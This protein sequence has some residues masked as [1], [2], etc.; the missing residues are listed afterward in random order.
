MAR[1]ARKKILFINPLV[2]AGIK[3]KT[4]P[5]GLAYVMTA[6]KNADIEFDF[7]DMY[8]HS[9]SLNHLRTHIQRN[10]YDIFSIG[11]LV[12]GLR[13]VRD[14]AS[15]IRECRPGAK[16][17]AGNTVASSIPE[18]ILRK[19]EVDIAV[20]GEGD[21]TIVELLR[22]LRDGRKFQ[23]IEGIAYLDHG[24]IRKNR[25]RAC[26]PDINTIGFPDWRL[27]NNLCY[28]E[29]IFS[30]VK[31]GDGRTV[32]YPLN[33]ARGCPFKCSYCYHVFKADPY[34]RYSED[35]ILDEIRRLY[36]EYNASVIQFSDELT[37]P[38]IS[39]IKR[40]VT[41][42]EALPFNIT[43]SAVT[44]PDLFRKK[45]VSLIRQMRDVGCLYLCMGLENA[46]QE[47]LDAM[48][49][50]VRVGRV[51]EHLTALQEGGVTP[52][53]SVIFGFPQ[54]TPKTIRET[55]SLCE[56]FN[57]VPGV[58]FLQPFPG[59]PIYDW[60]IQNRYIQDPFKYLLN[61]GDREVFHV[62]L[63]KMPTDEFIDIVV[64]GIYDLA[65]RLKRI[66]CSQFL[67]MLDEYHWQETFRDSFET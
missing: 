1:S 4:R 35:A 55:Y 48:N 9:L 42:L 64:S 33:A 2:Q 15:I 22:A 25:P 65:K 57:M 61:T 24:E 5:V 18:L 66:K 23:H 39:S 50:K 16:I 53:V 49:K 37:F 19:T 41:G 14:I 12:T 63:T 43:W 60:S 59:T 20:I 29:G 36:N 10:P 13:V 26:I 54:E 11:C 47:I 52:A 30:P 31:K 40:M 28:N 17:I 45:D 7:F 21:V 44:R 67:Q 6:A 32:A 62:N 38:N 27:F 51:I 46:S 34:R 8:A 3:R 56:R 58:G